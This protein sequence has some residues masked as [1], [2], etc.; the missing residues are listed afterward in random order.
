MGYKSLMQFAP[1]DVFEGRVLGSDG[2][3][4]PLATGSAADTGAKGVRRRFPSL[5][6]SR[7]RLCR[8]LAVAL[9]AAGVGVGVDLW[10]AH[11][12]MDG[13]LVAI[14]V[15]EKAMTVGRSNM[16][17]TA[18]SHAVD[19]SLGNLDQQ[20]LRSLKSDLQRACG[21]AAADVQD[22]ADRV[23]D[24][25][26]M[27]WHT[28]LREARSKYLSHNKVWQRY[29]RQCAQNAG[30]SDE[31]IRSE[32]EATYRSARRAVMAA[33][34]VAGGEGKRVSRILPPPR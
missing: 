25:R 15:S 23:G 29:F 11:R 6:G 12:E 3:W 22:A 17:S 18:E 32:I 14:Q 30:A 26:L 16:N 31:A 5:G 1:G 34:P 24:V 10:D 4:H 7:R 33:V 19:G 2:V 21:D 28:S 9:V 8:W 20:Q 27:V 13:L